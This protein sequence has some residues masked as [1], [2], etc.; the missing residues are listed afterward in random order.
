MAIAL[1]PFTALCGFL[2]VS[3]IAKHL[4]TNPEFSKIIPPSIYTTFLSASQSDDANDGLSQ[5][6]ALKDLWK[7]LITTD[8][9]NEHIKSL[10]SRYESRNNLDSQDDKGVRDLV[11]SISRDFPGDIGVLCVFMLN[12]IRLQPGEAIFLGAGEPHA[13]ISGGMFPFFPR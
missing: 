11:L 13:Y 9:H 7:A 2:P 4:D 12:I 8:P 1:T 3:R 6:E 10:L 5:K